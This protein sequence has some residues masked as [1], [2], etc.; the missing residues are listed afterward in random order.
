MKKIKSRLVTLIAVGFTGAV[1]TAYATNG[2]PINNGSAE[3]YTLS[4]IGDVPYGDT[5]IAA[6]PNFIDFINSD[7]KV[8]IVVH[9][10]DIKSG[11]SVCSNEYFMFVKAQLDRLQD[12]VVYTPGDNEWTDCHR[13]NNGKYLP[14]ERLAVIRDIF[15]PVPGETIGGRHKRV[16]TQANDPVHSDFVENIMWMESKVVFT[17]L[18]VPGSND[19]SLTTNPWGAPW[20]TPEFTALQTEE[21]T[22][23]EAANLDWLS[24]AF[25]TANANGAQ[26][27]VIFL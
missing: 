27:V 12:P 17:T 6:F 10:G 23:R 2:N 16:L 8:D 22:T 11:S 15:F 26:G 18:N 4:V 9:V 13:A 19:D 7:P 1:T 20:N 5:K 14:A 25:D 24:M 21:Q 3:K